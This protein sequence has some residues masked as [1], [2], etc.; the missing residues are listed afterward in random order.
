MRAKNHVWAEVKAV[1]SGEASFNGF[2][3]QG[4]T[5]DFVDKEGLRVRAGNG[6]NVIVTSAG[7]R[8]IK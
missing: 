2:L 3:E 4:D 7:N 8:D 6:G 1:S 5:R